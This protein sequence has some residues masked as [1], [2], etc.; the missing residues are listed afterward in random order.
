MSGVSLAPVLHLVDDEILRIKVD[1]RDE[2]FR[3]RVWRA[4]NQIAVAVV[5]QLPGHLP[6]R[7]VTE[8]L[9]NRVKS[10]YL[11]HARLGMYY[12]EADLDGTLWSVSFVGLGHGERCRLIRPD[13]RPVNRSLFDGLVGQHVDC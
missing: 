8:R 10:V 7:A 11:A 6:P 5:S 13:R 2:P 1:R 4:P 12:F 3:V 9:A